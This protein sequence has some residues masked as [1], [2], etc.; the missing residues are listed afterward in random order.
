MQCSRLG[1]GWLATRGG[2][3]G[4]DQARLPLRD[5]LNGPGL[6]QERRDIARAGAVKIF[7]NESALG[8]AGR[9]QSA[10]AELAKIVASACQF[11]DHCVERLLIQHQAVTLAFAA[12]Q[13][14]EF[15][16]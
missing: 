7:W 14:H 3:E 5:R 12:D 1:P 10:I 11:G 16:A 8:R 13:F 9:E 2:V 15:A 4:K 6:S